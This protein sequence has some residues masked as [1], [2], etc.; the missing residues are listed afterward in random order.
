[1]QTG[2]GL[3]RFGE[4][5]LLVGQV[6]LRF[7]PCLGGVLDGAAEGGLDPGEVN[8]SPRDFPQ[9]SPRGPR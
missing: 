4:E 3:A 1:V 9:S 5:R 2:R 8:T 7:A 6:L